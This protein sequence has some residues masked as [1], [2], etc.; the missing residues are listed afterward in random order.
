MENKIFLLGYKK[1]VFKYLQK[2]KFFI[3]S[4]KYEDPGFVILEAGFMNKIV[5][6]SNCPNGPMELIDNEKNGYLFKENSIKDF[7][8]SFKRMIDDNNDTKLKKKINLKKKCK[9]F[10]LFN[11]YQKFKK[12][13][14]NEN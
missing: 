5:L 6:S 3:L 7:L 14:I 2:C 8:N 1:N 11:H 12:I 13:L 10:T 9:E 4:S